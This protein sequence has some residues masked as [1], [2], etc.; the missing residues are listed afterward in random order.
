MRCSKVQKLLS[1]D[2]DGE[3]NEKRRRSVQA[4]VAGCARCQRFADGL[5][6]CEQVLDMLAVPEPRPGF[7]GRLMARLPQTRTRGAWL[8]DWLETLRPA[9]VAVGAIGLFFGVLLAGLMNG[10]QASER[11]TQEDR[12]QTLYAD[13]FDAFPG[14]STGARYLALLQETEE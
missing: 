13:C 12:S 14:D 5:P 2:L 11:S 4:H 9:P 7:T 8:R 3:L 10:D 6:G 1:A